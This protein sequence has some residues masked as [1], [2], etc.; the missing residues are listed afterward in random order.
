MKVLA[1]LAN[2]KKKSL[3]RFLFE[4]I[5]SDLKHKNITVDILD[6]YQ[7]QG[8]IPFYVQPN[9]GDSITE[10]ELADYPF[11]QEHKER[12]LAADMLLVVAPVYWYSVPGILKCWFD[13]ITNFAWKYTGSMQAWPLH[14]I[15]KAVV[16]TTMDIPWWYK[17]FIT[18][19]VIA[20]QFREIFK[21][22]GIKKVIIYEITS[23]HKLDQAIVSTHLQKILQKL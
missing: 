20:R 7:R 12:F 23:V 4:K 13:L 8:D 21:F 5:I 1:I 9:R 18:H 19:N 15:K 17:V 2:D 16:I 3:N 11:F 6:L 10:E 14:N 22:I